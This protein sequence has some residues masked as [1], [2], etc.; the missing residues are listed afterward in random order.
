MDQDGIMSFMGRIGVNGE[1]DQVAIMIAMYME[2]QYMGEFKWPEFKK[3]CQTL[4]VDSIQSWS[5]VVPRLRQELNN[6]ARYTAMYKYAFDF[7][8]EKGK[9]NVDVELACALW[10]LLIAQERCSF[11]DKWKAFVN[12]KFER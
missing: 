1:T 9:K 3:G 7:A 4:G 5:Q 11:L 8:Q 10:D 12:G 6:E 2:A